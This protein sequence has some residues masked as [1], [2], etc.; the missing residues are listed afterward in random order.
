MNESTKIKFCFYLIKNY[1]LKIEIKLIMK[2]TWTIKYLEKFVEQLQDLIKILFFLVNLLC[3]S[4]DVYLLEMLAENLVLDVVEHP[5]SK[6]ILV[7]VPV[8]VL[9][10]AL[11]QEHLCVIFLI[12]DPVD[13]IWNNS[14]S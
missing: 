5:D 12:L 3:G 14:R 8:E 13:T 10:V 9:P 6:E 1:L 7:V 4:R 11:V 2:L